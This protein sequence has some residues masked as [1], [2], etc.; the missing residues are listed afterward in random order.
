[1]RVVAELF[2]ADK[3]FLELLAR[4]FKGQFFYTFDL[5]KVVPPDHLVRQIDAGG[6]VLAQATAQRSRCGYHSDPIAC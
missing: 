3:P 2:E 6:G 1:M 4:L 5:D